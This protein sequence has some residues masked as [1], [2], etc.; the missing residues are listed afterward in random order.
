MNHRARTALPQ[1][2]VER[3]EHQLGAQI[4]PAL[5]KD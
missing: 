1:R 5:P 2:Y 3:L 4:F